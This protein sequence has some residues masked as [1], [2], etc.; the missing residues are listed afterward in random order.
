MAHFFPTKKLE[1]TLKGKKTQLEQIVQASEPDTDMAG[2]L[3]L[4]DWEFKTTMINMLRALMEKVDNM[5]KQMDSLNRQ[6]KIIRN[7]KKEMIEIRKKPLTEMKKIMETPQHFCDFYLSELYQILTV[8]LREKSLHASSKGRGNKP[9]VV[10]QSIL[11]FL[12]R[13]TL[14][15]NNF[16][17]A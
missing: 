6:M 4:P 13:S 8:N 9:F 10:S 3:A 11:L 12:K 7:N 14:R 17:R 5:Q 15:R 1:D 16:A 2:M